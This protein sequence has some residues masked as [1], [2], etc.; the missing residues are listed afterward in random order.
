MCAC[1]YCVLWNVV[2]SMY[3]FFGGGLRVSI[4]E[5]QLFVT[6]GSGVGGGGWGVLL[7]ERALKRDKT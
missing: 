1:F 2:S 7:S 4:Y 3:V 6:T 5:Q